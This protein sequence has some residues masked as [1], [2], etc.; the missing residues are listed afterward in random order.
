MV[1]TRRSSSASKRFCAATSSSSRPTKRSKAAAEPASSS[2]ASEVPIDNQAPVSDPGSISGDPELR[3]SDPQ[4]NDAERPVTTTDV[5]AMETDTN[6]ELEGLVTPTPAGEVVVEAEKSKSSKK[7]I[8]KAP[9]AKLLSQFPQNPHLVMRGSVFTVG[10][11]ACDLCIRDH[12][13]PNVLCELRQS[14]HG[15]PSV[16]SLEI[17]GNGVLVQVNGK[18]YQRSTCVHLRGGDEIIFTTPGK[19]AY[20]SFYKFFEKLSTFRN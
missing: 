6:P 5:P 14:E 12:S 3:T 8:A 18:I 2:S 20:V 9:W 1:D 19:H 4:S 13:M 11:R 17:I 10:R 15:G 7:R 16:A